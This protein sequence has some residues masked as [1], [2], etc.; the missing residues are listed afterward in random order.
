MYFLNASSEGIQN[1][2]A[3]HEVV[4]VVCDGDTSLGDRLAIRQ[5]M[6]NVI[7]TNPDML[8]YTL[9]PEVCTIQIC[10]M[11]NIIHYFTVVAQ[12]MESNL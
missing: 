12:S 11:H 5:G 1:D 4:P 8:H 7:L 6:G 9:L 2:N 3:H 10:R